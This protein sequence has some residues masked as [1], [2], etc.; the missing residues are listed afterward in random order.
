MKDEII[1]GRNS[2]LEALTAGKRKISRLVIADSTSGQ[3]LEQIKKIAAKQNITLHQWNRKRI[4]SVCG[5][6]R[7]QGV[8]VIISQR[9]IYNLQDIFHRIEQKRES[10]FLLILDRIEDPRNLG[11]L[12]RTAE[13]AGVHGVIISKHESCG[14]TP[15]VAKASAGATEYMPIVQ[16]SNLAMVCDQLKEKGIWLFGADPGGKTYWSDTDFTIPLAILL[17]SEG[18]GLKNILK[19]KCDFLISIPMRGCISSL[20]V[21]TAGGVFLYE[22]VKQ[23]NL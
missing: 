19:K 20:N 3:K 13:S 12:I 23:R 15:T 5:T 21:A 14:V 8:A 22:V 7:H 11:A 1:Y 6:D 10:A 18:R 9:K 4:D 17:G 2:V 16:V